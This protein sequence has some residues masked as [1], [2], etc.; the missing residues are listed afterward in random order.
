MKP[1]AQD[2][3]RVIGAYF[4]PDGFVS[5]VVCFGL[6]LEVDM[7]KRFISDQVGGDNL[8]PRDIRVASRHGWELGEEAES[9]LRSRL[10]DRGVVSEIYWT[11]YAKT[12]A[13]KRRALSLCIGEGAATG[14][15]KLF[16]H[17]R[18]SV[19]KLCPACRGRS[20]L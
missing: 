13:E 11:R 18:N 5:Q 15:L 12:D 19:E 9:F 10:G 20:A 2:S 6:K 17:D 1:L 3:A 8:S 7:F 4:C 14:C 16:M